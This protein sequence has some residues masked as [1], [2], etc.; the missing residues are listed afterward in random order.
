MR[1]HVS[2]LVLKKQGKISDEKGLTWLFSEY[3]LTSEAA[4]CLVQTLICALSVCIRIP[5]S[6][7]YLVARKALYRSIAIDRFISTE[8]LPQIKHWLVEKPI[9]ASIYSPDNGQ[10]SI[11][12]AWAK[13]GAVVG[14][15]Y[16]LA[17]LKVVTAALDIIKRKNLRV[18][19]TQ[20]RYNMAYEFAVSAANITGLICVEAD[21]GT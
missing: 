15:G 16:H 5:S 3:L 14:V 12:D 2:G 20:A 13:S 10:D 4:S 11:L 21:N 6:S 17:A 8:S 1:K 7:V 18:M 9:S 19:S